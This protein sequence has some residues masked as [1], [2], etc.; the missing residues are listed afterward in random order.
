MRHTAIVIIALFSVTSLVAQNVYDAYPE[1]VQSTKI[2][3][4]QPEMKEEV[5]NAKETKDNR[6]DS[7]V[8]TGFT[9]GMKLHIGYAF[10]KSPKYLFGDGTL[11]EDNSLPKDGVT[12]GL[13]GELRIHMFN[14][15]HLGGE[16]GMSMMPL[17]KSGSSLR[18]GW[19]GVL[20]D[21]YGTVGKA[22]LCI[23]GMIGG[24]KTKKLY[25]PNEGT[26]IVAEDGN[27]YNAL[28]QTTSYFLLDP[29]VGLE[30]SLTKRM[31]LLI[32]IDYMLPF[33][34]GK[35][36]YPSGPR[37]YVG[38]MFGKHDQHQSRR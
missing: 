7:K 24:G 6:R 26:S 33:K 21:Y 5:K 35:F 19:G 37:L 15:V 10:M 29:Y 3:Q 32:K 27:T 38:L 18:S 4:N 34:S 13:G 20:C 25:V 31:S 22:Q 16:G 36:L 14:H 23:G 11:P 9:G 2:E 30:A 8:V 28:Y 12:M 1:R 17:M